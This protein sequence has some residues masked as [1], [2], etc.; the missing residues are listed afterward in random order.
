MLLEM[1]PTSTAKF[2]SDLLSK[3]EEEST[4]MGVVFLRLLIASLWAALQPY[5]PYI[6]GIFF[7]IVLIA[8]VKALFGE[9]GMLGSVLY[10]VFF[11]GTLGIIVA[12]YGLEIFFNAY[13]DLISFLIYVVSFRLT[14]LILKKFSGVY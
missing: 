3:I 6:I 1:S 12:I 13:F 10:H 8:M 2:I 9:T 11:F 4:K 14:G 7:L 5:L